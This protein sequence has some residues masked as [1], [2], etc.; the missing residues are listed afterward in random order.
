MTIEFKKAY[1][2][3]YDDS[4]FEYCEYMLVRE[5][6]CGNFRIYRWDT[7]NN[8]N[9]MKLEKCEQ[10]LYGEPMN[11]FY[12]EPMNDTDQSF[13]TLKQAIEYCK[14]LNKRG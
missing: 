6:K 13:D 10:G 4:G 11:T 14:K 5:S 2:T 8:Y 9:V 7:K 12:F 1:W 3:K